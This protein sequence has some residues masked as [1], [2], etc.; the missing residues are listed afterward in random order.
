MELKLEFNQP[1]EVSQGDQPDFIVVQASLS[2]FPDENGNYLPDSFLKKMELPRMF[3]SH[4]QALGVSGATI[5][6]RG[7]TTS[8]S[9][10]TVV[11]R[12]TMKASL[13]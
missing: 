13:S 1:I 11:S 12:F 10:L 9:A 8:M 7:T 5:T 4:S 6:M 3:T 2:E